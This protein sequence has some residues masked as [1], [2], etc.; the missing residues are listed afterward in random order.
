MAPARG[1]AP[2]IE[3]SAIE[4]I[5]E[6]VRKKRA[7]ALTAAVD[8]H[9]D[10]RADHDVLSAAERHLQLRHDIPSGFAA[11]GQLRRAEHFEHRRPASTVAVLKEAAAEGRT[12]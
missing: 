9:A 11:A 10:A 5:P 4:P 7:A 6:E 1:L 2:A 8:R 12:P 3:E